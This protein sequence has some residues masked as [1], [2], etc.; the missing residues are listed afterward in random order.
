MN[1]NQPSGETLSLARQNVKD[2]LLKSDA[3]CSLPPDKQKEIANHTVQIASYLAEPDGIRGNKLPTTKRQKTA[4]EDPYAIGLEND[5]LRRAEIASN[6]TRTGVRED[7]TKRANSPKFQAQ[8]ARE[9][10]AVAGALLQSVNFPTFVSGLISGVFH[11]IVQ[12]SIEQMEAYG[13]LV[14][15]VAKTIDQ[16]RDENVSANQGRDHLVDQFPDLFVVDID[17]GDFGDENGGPRV[18]LRD[19]ADESEALKRVNTLPVDGGQISSLDD[20]SI[21]K[22]LVPAARTQLATSRQQLLAT[23]VLMGINRIVVTDGKISAKVMYNFQARDNLKFRRSATQFDYARNASGQLERMY[24]SEGEYD[25]GEEGGEE[26][27]TTNLS[28]SKDGA[29]SEDVEEEKRDG[30]YYSKGTYKHTQSPVV[31]LASASQESTDAALQTKASLAGTVEVNFKSDFLPLE[32]MAD[33]FQIAM[34]QNAANPKQQSGA[35]GASAPPSSGNDSSNPSP[36]S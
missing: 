18:R 26:R 4:L 14:A 2:L 13:R 11:S 24:G 36:T 27:R 8:A 23:M 32:K 15:D 21:E 20:E 1:N 16:F 22:K 29:K 6:P 7:L 33:S 31:T 10:A 12:S 25:Y 3:F 17:T 5:A 30:S 9:G 28:K 19:D 35:R 34:I